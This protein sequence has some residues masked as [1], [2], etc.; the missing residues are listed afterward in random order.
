MWAS[1]CPFQLEAE[2]YRDSITVVRDRLPFLT[3]ADK[4]Q[5]L[6]RTAESLFF[7]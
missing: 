6:R 7:Q 2:T 4:D 1:D 5:M 3:A